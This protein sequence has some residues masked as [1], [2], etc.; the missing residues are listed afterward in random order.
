MASYTWARAIDTDSTSNSLRRAQRGYAA[1][2]VRHLGTAAATYDI[3]FPESNVIT[4]ALLAHWSV[5]AKLSAQSALPID[6]VASAVADPLTGELV[7]IR[8]NIVPGESLYVDDNT[9][10]G[11]RRIN[12]AAFSIP[13]AGTSGNLGRN[14]L[15]GFPLWQVDFAVH[16]E[17]PLRKQVKMQFRAEAFNLLNHPNF[18]GIQT[19]LTANNFGQATNMTNRQLGGVSQLYQIGGPRSIQL[20]LKLRF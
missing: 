17:F 19:V 3:P 10:P 2:D 20:A 7:S 5:D 12:R 4:R 13:T 8:P 14:A 11:G 16:R 6:L 1:F 18:G 9:V 15:R